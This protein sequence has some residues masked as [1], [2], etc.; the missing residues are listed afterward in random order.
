MPRHD[1]PPHR[2]E[3]R[4]TSTFLVLGVVFL[5]IGVGTAF[6]AENAGSG[7]AFLAVGITF[8][9]ISSSDHGE[10]EEG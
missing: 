6:G 1:D 3:H 2:P 4:R 10:N 7:I 8:L 5:V 9:I